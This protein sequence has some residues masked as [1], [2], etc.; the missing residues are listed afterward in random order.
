MPETFDEIFDE[1]VNRI[2]RGQRLED[3]LAS[4]PEHA[5]ELEPLL[6]AMLEAQMAYT[7]A[8]SP[9]AK[10]AARQ[11]FNAA[12]EGLE[13]GREKGQLLFPRIGG[14]SR[15]WGAVAAVLLVA[16]IGYFGV[17]PAL[18][19]TGPGLQPGPEGNFALLISDE[20]NAIGDFQSLSV[21]ISKIGLQLE[22]EAG[23]WIE[24][25]PEVEAVDLT[26]L[27]GDKA[28][29]IWGGDVPEGQYTK[30]FIHVSDVS[31]VL[32]ETGR[33]VDVKLPSEK[34]QISKPFEVT[35][36]E[37]TSFVYDLTVVAAGSPQSGIKYILKPQIGQSGADQRFERI[38]G[39]GGDRRR[40]D[41]GPSLPPQERNPRR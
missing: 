12:L 21:S 32:R 2:N 3:C 22:G 9:T 6:R 20:V 13:R 7:F 33:P 24:L 27:Q 35:S 1:C 37:V 4:Y 30:V 19:P 39:K 40:Q 36:D 34:L 17:R 11:R 18:F 5:E 10:M 25:D 38:D 8:P 41:H 28:Q 26:L 29:E 23:R 31:G 14:R 15:A 16:L